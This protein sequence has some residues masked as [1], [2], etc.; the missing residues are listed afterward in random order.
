LRL[1]PLPSSLSLPSPVRR[2]QA[3]PVLRTWRKTWANA[4]RRTSA[5]VQS[6]SVDQET[7]GSN[8]DPTD[9]MQILWLS[10][11]ILLE[12]RTATGSFQFKIL[13]IGLTICYLMSRGKLRWTGGWL[14][15]ICQRLLAGINNLNKPSGTASLV[16]IPPRSSERTVGVASVHLHSL[17]ATPRLTTLPSLELGLVAGAPDLIKEHMRRVREMYRGGRVV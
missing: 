5:S 1:T 2:H 15:S 8:A 11:D 4:E 7:R 9:L 17:I 10:G 16:G 12:A 6:V 13:T 14:L 3:S